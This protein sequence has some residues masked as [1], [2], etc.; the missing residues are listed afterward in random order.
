MIRGGSLVGKRLGTLFKSSKITPQLLAKRT[1][2]ATNRSKGLVGIAGLAGRR[3]LPP[4]PQ[5][6]SSLKKLI[7]TQLFTTSAIKTL[8]TGLKAT[9]K[10]IYDDSLSLVY[11]NGKMFVVRGGP[12]IMQDGNRIE[13]PL[14]LE[15]NQGGRKLL[16]ESCED[17]SDCIHG[18]CGR[19]KRGDDDLYCCGETSLHFGY[20]YC[21]GVTPA[22]EICWFDEQC[23]NEGKSVSV[24]ST[25]R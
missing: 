8:S 13:E 12:G 11:S 5:G 7:A 17:D 1:V 21:E 14:R 24:S 23:M 9:G 16:F 2:F 4:P 18:E 25:Y 20:Y 19:L 6:S 10:T 3:R 15:P 22:G